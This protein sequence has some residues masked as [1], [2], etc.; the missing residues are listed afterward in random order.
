MNDLLIA[1]DAIHGPMA[2]L[3]NNYFL[4]LIEIGCVLMQGFTLILN[5]LVLVSVEFAFNPVI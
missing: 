1:M 5:K 3:I 2:S 4:H